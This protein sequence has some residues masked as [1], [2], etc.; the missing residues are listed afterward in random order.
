LAVAFC[1][2]LIQTAN[3]AFG[4]QS[5]SFKRKETGAGLLRESREHCARRVADA[6]L[7]AANP[8]ST[9]LQTVRSAGR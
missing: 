9:V 1:R 4:H 7:A 5:M 2:V 6:F 8:R 3:V